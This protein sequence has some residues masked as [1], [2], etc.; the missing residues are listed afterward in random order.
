MAL[1]I[2]THKI[3]LGSAKFEPAREQ[4]AGG[5]KKGRPSVVPDTFK[6]LVYG[7]EK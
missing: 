6:V 7:M 4:P 3:Y 5:K 1:D 2:T